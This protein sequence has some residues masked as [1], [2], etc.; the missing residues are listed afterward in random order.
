VKSARN[1]RKEERTVIQIAEHL[2]PYPNLMWTLAKQ[3]GV[4]HAVSQA[5]DAQGAPVWDFM[6]LLHL[7]QRFAGNGLDL[8]VIEGGGPPLDRV[9]LEQPGADEDLD[10]YCDFVRNM[11]AAGIPV[12]CYNW[13]AVFNWMRT[14]TT[15]PAR[16]GA[17]VSGYDHDLMRNAPLTE[18]GEVSEDQLWTSLEKFLKRVVPAA[19]DAGVLL[20]IHPDDPPLSPIRGVSRIVRSPDAIRQIIDL[21]PSPNNG[22]TLCQGNFS[23]MGA[24]IP[25]EIHAFGERGAIHFVHFRDVKGTPDHF[26]E[27]FH[28]EGQTDMFAAMRAYHEINWTGPMR[29]DHVPTFAGEGNDNP[30][31]EVLGRLYALGYI[32]GLLEGVRATIGD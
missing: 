27:T 16:G 25:A 5:A 1:S 23:A 20:A 3:A 15:I 13:M 19:E 18:A 17:M 4:T 21:V 9:R 24:D 26:V 2:A 31:Y 30:G 6:S 12:L 29:P 14:S 10:V 7:K 8:A 32:K 11:G 28:E 22:I